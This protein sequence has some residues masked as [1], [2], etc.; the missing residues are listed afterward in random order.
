MELIS[1]KEVMREIIRSTKQE[2]N[3][4][5]FIGVCCVCCWQDHVFTVVLALFSPYGTPT[6]H[7]ALHN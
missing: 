6:K 2:R 1:W 3:T 5:Q 7:L 4:H